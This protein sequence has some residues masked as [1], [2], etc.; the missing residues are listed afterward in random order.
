MTPAH[1]NATAVEVVW[2]A[3]K[4]RLINA[5]GGLTSTALHNLLRAYGYNG[6]EAALHNL[7]ANDARFVYHPAQPDNLWSIQQ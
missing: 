5:R 6:S 2:L 1:N 4:A 7:L 3:L